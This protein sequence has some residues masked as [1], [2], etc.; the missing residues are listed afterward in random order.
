[1]GFW[2]PESPK[3]WEASAWSGHCPIASH[4]C[5]N[6]VPCFVKH[7]KSFVAESVSPLAPTV[8]QARTSPL[9]PPVQG[10][11]TT[12]YLS[13]FIILIFFSSTSLLLPTPFPLPSCTP[14][15][16]C[17]PMDCSLPGSFVHGRF[18]ARILEWVAISFSKWVAIFFSILERF[19]EPPAVTAADVSE[20]P[21]LD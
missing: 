9:T 11:G 17:N 1:M 8:P 13:D 18:H 6:P 5:R 16:S 10:V 7:S 4:R 2:V 20:S 14:A 3:G 15:Q 12:G 21:E 19:K